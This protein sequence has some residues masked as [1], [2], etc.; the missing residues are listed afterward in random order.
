M[1]A[2]IRDETSTPEIARLLEANL[3]DDLRRANLQGVNSNLQLTVREKQDALAGGLVG[4]TAYGWLHIKVLWIRKGV[5]RARPW[6][7]TDTTGH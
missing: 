7:R 3:L 1:A 5:Q 2:E 4:D 6:R